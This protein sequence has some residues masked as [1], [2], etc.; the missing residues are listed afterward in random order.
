[1]ASVTEILPVFLMKLF[2]PYAKRP[3]ETGRFTRPE[4]SEGGRKAISRARKPFLAPRRGAK[5]AEETQSTTES[6]ERLH[7]VKLCVSFVP[8]V[9]KSFSA[10]INH[11]GKTA[12]PLFK[13][14]K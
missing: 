10:A 11:E 14:T 4:R 1:M 8:F 13:P 6:Y 5:S 7:F 3:S 9:S 12:S 2:F